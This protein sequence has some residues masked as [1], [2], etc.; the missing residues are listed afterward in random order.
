MEIYRERLSPTP[1]LFVATAL[2]IPASLLV[3]LPISMVAGVIAAIVSYAAAVVILLATTPK[4]VVTSDELIAGRARL[5]RDV[6][7]EVSAYR[8]AEATLQ[9]GRL[10]DAR[11]WLLIRG[12]I[13]PVVKVELR[14]D[15]DP[16]PYWLV[17]T[18]RPDELVAALARS[19][20]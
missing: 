19:S 15:E 9:R 16:T 2:L 3:F 1:W 5:P 12:W 4:L 20:D 6:V 11:A 13:H 14:D 10:L 17:S 7:G 8:G 18:R